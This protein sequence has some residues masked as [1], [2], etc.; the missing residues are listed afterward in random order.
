[1]LP[2]PGFPDGILGAAY[3][4]PYPSCRLLRGPVGLGLGVAS[5]LADSLFDGALYLMSAA[6]DAIFVHDGPLGCDWFTPSPEK[7]R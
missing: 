5:H 6:R 7:L 3:S 4:V 1:M 2:L